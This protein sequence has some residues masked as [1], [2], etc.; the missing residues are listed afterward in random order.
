MDPA[1]VLDGGI[2]GPMRCVGKA[3]GK[4]TAPP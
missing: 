4:G 3:A 2:R 1:E